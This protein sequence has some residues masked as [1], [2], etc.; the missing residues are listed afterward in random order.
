MDICI[1]SGYFNPIHPGHISLIQDIRSKYPKCKLIAIVNNDKQVGLKGAVPFMDEETRLY[2]VQNIKGVDEAVLSIDQDQA[3]VES[4]ELIKYDNRH[5]NSIICFCN[6]GDRSPTS[7]A[8]PEVRFCIANNI[9]LEY[10]FGDDKTYS[11]S[12]MLQ[13]AY[14]WLHSHYFN[15]LL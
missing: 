13:K 15:T 1:F 3:V 12:Q 7:S 2:I 9:Y 11:S 14:I 5:R 10:G 4:L 8:V 6:G